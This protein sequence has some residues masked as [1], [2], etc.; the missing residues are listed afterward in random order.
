M[1]TGLSGCVALLPVKA[2]SEAKRRLAPALGPSE[3]ASFARSMADH[4]LLATAPLTAAVV[5]DDPD[6]AAWAEERGAILLVEPGL[7]LNGAVTAGVEALARA[8]A[9]EVLVVHAD[10]PL[11]SGLAG[12]A[13]FDGVTLV[14]DRRDDGTNVCCV[15]ARAGFH[16]SY[17]P[18]S[19]VRHLAEAEQL[20]LGV[21]VVRE[22][23]LAWDVDVPA[24]I[25][26]GLPEF[27][28]AG[29]SG[30]SDSA[31]SDSATSQ[32][33]TRRG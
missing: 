9:D 29:S 6:V 3:R 10:L 17:G 2:F 16:F 8:G 30:P 23:L 21:R 13:G 33:S 32:E 27:M 20:G 14:P 15:P 24:D 18:S 19:F 31:V 11:A 7:G 12:L 4:V 25:P 22:P 1:L 28:S 5:C 26:A